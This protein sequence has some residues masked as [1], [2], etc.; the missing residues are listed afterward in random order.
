MPNGYQESHQGDVLTT[1]APEF[2]PQHVKDIANQLYGLT[3]TLS[4]L[5]SERDLNFRFDTDTGDQYVIK[6]ANTAEDPAVI[7]MQI[8][9]LEHIGVVDPGLPV[10]EVLYS[11]NGGAI[12]TIQAENGTTHVVR[13]LTYLLGNPPKDD[14]ADHALLRPLGTCLARLTSA[15]QGFFHP[16]ADHD[17][18]WNLKHTPRL[19]DY[20][21][22]VAGSKHRALAAYFLDRFEQ[23]VLPVIP[24]LRAQ[25]LH[26]DLVPDN[27]VVAEDDPGCIT[28]IID[29][30]DMTHTLLVVDLATTIAATIF[31]HPDPV[32]AAAEIITGYH[33]T[34]PLK[35]AEL[36]LLYD[37][38]AARLT[39]LNVIASWRVTLHP[40]NRAYI[41]GSLEKGWDTLESW[42][43][44]DP[45]EATRKFFRVCG[46]WEMEDGKPPIKVQTE[47]LQSHLQRRKRLL[48]PLDW[49]FYDRPLH[50]VRGEGVWV[51]DNDGNR[52]LDAYNNV[53]HVGHCHPHVVNAIARQSRRLNISTRYLHG[54]ILELAEQITQRMPDPLSVCTFVCTGTEANEL[55]WQMSKMV[56]GNRGALISKFSYHGNSNSTIQFSTEVTPEEKLPSHVVTFSPPISNTPFHK[57]DSDIS[58]SI[59]SLNEQGHR[60]AMLL[61]DS[62]FTCDGIYPSP[63]GYLSTLFAETRSVGGLCVADEVQAGFGRLGHHFWGF[64]YDDVVPDIVTMGKP[65][66]NG[67]PIAAVVTRPE[68]A[69]ALAV[70]TGY[71]NT[72]GGNPVSCAAGLAVLEVLEKEGLQR[73]ALDVGEYLFERLT[74][75]Q[76]EYPVIG[77]VRGSGLHQGVE[78]VK[79][80]GRPDPDLTDRI[81]NQLRENGVLIGTAGHLYHVLK[82]RPPLVFQREHAEILLETLTITLSEL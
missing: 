24:K 76:S 9:A 14:P 82:I 66:G 38:I 5:D 2:S 43:Q 39:M 28:G 56:S 36:L 6:I 48:G 8:K 33:E 81:E 68:I 74:A 46:L 3:G 35:R 32:G 29:F 60:P 23:N 49:L 34:V 40:Y 50:L 15:L 58:C 4:P 17:L 72:F 71:F 1:P 69:E 62:V 70:N 11:R 27:I 47:T 10:P 78:I 54:L 55:A 21:P 44:Q 80:D 18:L 65:M 53:P 42:R 26:N 61:F 16:A 25:I 57:P 63:K 13:V 75:L 77:E 7:D 73:N 64:Q 41:T 31:I 19:R 22:H 37:L 45:E 67:H 52:Y 20:L 30:G 51:Y 12:E 59:K 79:P